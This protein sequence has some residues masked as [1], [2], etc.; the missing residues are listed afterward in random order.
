M[1]ADGIAGT[2]LV[3]TATVAWAGDDAVE[4][5]NTDADI[6]GSAQGLF[7]M[8]TNGIGAFLGAQASGLVIEGLFTHDGVRDWHHIWL[9]FSGYALVV[10][11]AF[12]VLFRHQHEVPEAGV[13]AH[14]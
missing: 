10:A 6:R 12:A 11:V 9:S 13:A 8:M 7:M 3:D 2:E 5:N 1:L 14:S 4:E